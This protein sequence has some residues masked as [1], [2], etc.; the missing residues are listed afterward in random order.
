MTELELRQ[1]VVRTA[2]AYLGC[3]EADGSHRKIVDVY[4]AYKPLPLGYKVTYTD[5]WCDAFVSAVSILCGLTDII[6]VECGCGR[7]IDLFKGLGIWVENDAYVPTMGD[8]IMYSW[9]DDGVG[10]CTE[11]ASHI[12][13]VVSCDGRSIK[14]IEGNISNSVGYRTLEVNGQ[15]I[16][17]YAVPHYEKHATKESMTLGEFG[18]MFGEYTKTLNDNDSGDWSEEARAWAISSGIIAGIGNGED[19]E[20]N[21]A[22]EAPLTRE[23]F[24]TML[25]RF[26][27]LISVA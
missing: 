23:Q 16:R 1:K 3:K 22:W 13:Y 20:P 17:G 14:I 11:G 8:I 12:G 4:N 21:Y 24:V 25:Y 19:G 2:E 5:A 10:D 26:A 9:R 27:K 6:P 7:H 15:Y 18:R